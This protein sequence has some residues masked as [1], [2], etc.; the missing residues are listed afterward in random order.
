MRGKLKLMFILIA[1]VIVALSTIATSQIIKS[2]THVEKG[3]M[4]LLAEATKKMVEAGIDQDVSFEL[5]IIEA[6]NDIPVIIIDEDD[7]LLSYRNIDKLDKYPQLAPKYVERMKEQHEPIEILYASGDKQ[8]IYYDD[9]FLKRN[10]FYFAIIQALVVIAFIAI[11]ANIFVVQKRAEQDRVW[12][13]LSRETAHQLGTPITSLLAWVEILKEENVNQTY[14]EEMTKD[15]TRL[16]TVAE[17]FS[18]IGSIPELKIESLNEILTRSAEYMQK[19]VSNRIELTCNIKDEIFLPMNV[20]LFEWVIENL[21][22]NAVD[23][24]NGEGKIHIEAKIEDEK[25][26]IDVSDTGKGI[27]KSDF[28]TVFNPG[29]TTKKRGWGLGLSLVK[30]I[31]E[32]YHKGKIFVKHSEV[33]VGTTFRILLPL[34]N[35]IKK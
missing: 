31:I 3:K 4:Q 28:H 6:N 22:K 34:Q 20:S 11:S 23:A 26:A 25:V 30:R 32:E 8:F 1:I 15:V 13:G 17:R 35:E 33:G 2:I 9:S 19:R 29:F 21:C 12:V 27:A 14:V 18:K 10:V 7:N 24:M 16:R 5:Q